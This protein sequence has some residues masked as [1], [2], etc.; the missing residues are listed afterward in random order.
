MSGRIH[1]S[2]ESLD[3]L[4]KNKEGKIDD[5]P[6]ELKKLM[7]IPDV[8]TRRKN[9]N[10]RIEEMGNNAILFRKKQQSPNIDID[11]INDTYNFDDDISKISIGSKLINDNGDTVTVNGILQTE[12]RLFLDIDESNDSIVVLSEYDDRFGFIKI[13]DNVI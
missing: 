12:D 13:K 2:K 9:R 7:S 3:F 6:D 5:M 1:L 8:E 10:R 4:K 11:E